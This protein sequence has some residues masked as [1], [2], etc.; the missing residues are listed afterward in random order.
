MI[1]TERLLLRPYR[2]EDLNPLYEYLA[3]LEVV[4]YEPYRPVSGLQE[5]R[6]ILEARMRSPEFL[7]VEH[8]AEG[9]LIGNLY[10]GHREFDALELGYVFHRAYWGQG[11][12]AEACRAAV[13][14]AFEAGAH[15]IYAECD[16]Q[17]TASWRL[18]ERLG[19]AR[20]AHFRQNV[21]FWQDENGRPLWKDTYVYALLR[22]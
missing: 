1:K 21:F 11:Y 17:N 18:L 3:D 19:F 15:R 2:A 13:R 6:E 7:A 8:Q 16:P 9:R 12:A 22:E 4:K 5:A 20:E 14:T 10:L